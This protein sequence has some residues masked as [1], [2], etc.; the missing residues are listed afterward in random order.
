MCTSLD[1]TLRSS[2]V[3]EV[4]EAVK[5]IEEDQEVEKGATSADIRRQVSGLRCQ[6]TSTSKLLRFSDR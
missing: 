4:V 1:S 5:V 2:E 6:R 3:I